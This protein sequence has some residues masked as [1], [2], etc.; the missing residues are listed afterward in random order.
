MEFI[1]DIQNGDWWY[2]H[3]FLLV[4]LCFFLCLFRFIIY[5]LNYFF[6]PPLMY[7]SGP[8][9]LLSAYLVC[10]IHSKLSAVMPDHLP[11]AHRLE[12]SDCRVEMPLNGHSIQSPAVKSLLRPWSTAI[13]IQIWIETSI[14]QGRLSWPLPN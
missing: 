5:S 12:T 3:H 8:C 7:F 9:F 10:N 4:A 6:S 2:T 1:G 13:I 11:S 14:P